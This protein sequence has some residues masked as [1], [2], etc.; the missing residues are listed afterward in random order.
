[1]KRLLRPFSR[2]VGRKVN[3][4]VAQ[5]LAG[6]EAR[7]EQRLRQEFARHL[8]KPALP[9]MNHDGAPFMPWSSCSAADF[10]HPRYHEIC[11]MLFAPPVWHR[12]M[13]EWAFVV[14]HLLSSGQVGA[15][16]RGLVFGVGRESLP[17]LFAGLGASIVATDAPASALAGG[18]DWN[19]SG[20]HIDALAALRQAHLCPDEL[21][22]QR[23]SFRHCDM[24]HIDADLRDFDFTWSSCCLEHLGSLEGGLQLV[25]NSVEQCLRPGG[26]AVHTTELNVGSDT[27][28]ATSGLTVI[29]RRRD[30]LGLVQR[31]RERGHDAM[32]FLPAPDAHVLDYHVDTPPYSADLHLKL[33]LAGHITT[34]AG[35]VVRRGSA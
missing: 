30:L 34:S 28:T 23:V 22:D 31:L 15:G 29:Y 13:W 27:A 32:P 16:R 7:I 33:E 14:H 9:P 12:K 11:A 10:L 19:G 24:T 1:L 21:F 35:I 6:A 4:A 2:W 17:A 8:F 5:E 20:E 3:A 25:I 18:A 26:I